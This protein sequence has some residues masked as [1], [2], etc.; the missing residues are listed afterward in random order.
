MENFFKESKNPFHSGKIPSQRFRSNEAY[1][2]FVSL[3]Y[4]IFSIVQKTICQRIWQGCS[5]KTLSDRA[6]SHAVRIEEK[7]EKLYT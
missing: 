4:K 2:Y 1:L 6:I 3:A 5:F 7:E